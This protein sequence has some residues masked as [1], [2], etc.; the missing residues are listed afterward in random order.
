MYKLGSVLLSATMAASLGACGSQTEQNQTS[1]NAM[2]APAEPLGNTPA[3]D[4]A[5]EPDFPTDAARQSD[6]KAEEAPA[7]TAVRRPGRPAQKDQP[8][9]RPAEPV[10]PH[11]GH[12]M[13]NMTHNRLASA[14]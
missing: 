14:S 11:A 1:Q 2:V 12:D 7:P 6:R 10:D 13:G 8:A 9:P 4:N 5:V 3:V